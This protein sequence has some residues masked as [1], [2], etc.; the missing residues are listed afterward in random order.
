[1]NETKSK[2]HA[3]NGWNVGCVGTSGH[4]PYYNGTLIDIS[5]TPITDIRVDKN[6]MT[7]TFEV[8]NK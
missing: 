6:W 1:M 7:Q 8:R 4:Y 3:V 5:V 2:C